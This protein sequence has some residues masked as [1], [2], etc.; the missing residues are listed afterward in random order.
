MAI[1][2]EGKS[3]GKQCQLQSEGREKDMSSTAKWIIGILITISLLFSGGTSGYILGRI[4]KVDTDLQ[5][6]KMVAARDALTLAKEQSTISSQ[7]VRDYVLKTDY[8]SDIDDLKKSFVRMSE[9]MEIKMDSVLGQKDS[10]V[11]V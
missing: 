6:H 9:K 7:I 10:T 1:V 11:P 4:D 5:T 8:R 2:G 3:N